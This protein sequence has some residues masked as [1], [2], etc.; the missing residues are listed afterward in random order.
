MEKHSA[1]TGKQGK[2]ESETFN[3][4]RS[5]G[6]DNT[7]SN[8]LSLSYVWRG[9][10]YQYLCISEFGLCNDDIHSLQLSALK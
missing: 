10:Q 3:G 4:K 2:G 6:K 7:R 9:H 8:R 1:E 5:E